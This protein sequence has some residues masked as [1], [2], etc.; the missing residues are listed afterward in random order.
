MGV[1]VL[2]G[3]AIV[4]KVHGATFEAFS[5][6]NYRIRSYRA[7]HNAFEMGHSL[8]GLW[9]TAPLDILCFFVHVA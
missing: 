9:Q 1:L 8:A 7:S 5:V 4:W 2:V 3:L 6:H